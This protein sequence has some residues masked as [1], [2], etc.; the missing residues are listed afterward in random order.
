MALELHLYLANGV[1]VELELTLNRVGVELELC[2][3]LS[4][5]SW[6]GVGVGPERSWSGVEVGCFLQHRFNSYMFGGVLS[7]DERSR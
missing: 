1:G 7:D 5:R 4:E 3:M 6:S 2:F